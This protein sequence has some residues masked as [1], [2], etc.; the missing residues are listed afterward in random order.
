MPTPAEL[1][2]SLKILTGGVDELTLKNL[3]L[4]LENKGLQREIEKLRETLQ[5]RSSAGDAHDVYS[6]D[7][8][9]ESLNTANCEDNSLSISKADAA[10]E[11][12]QDQTQA[13]SSPPDEQDNRQ[14]T[15]DFQYWK[16]DPHD[17]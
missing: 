4:E 1:R 14:S 9:L 11:S 13:K 16:E 17:A 15:P 10:T 12:E 8:P 2:D 7:A 3:A 6:P 5:S